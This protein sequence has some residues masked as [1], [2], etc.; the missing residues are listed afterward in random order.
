MHSVLIVFEKPNKT[1]EREKLNN[2][3]PKFYNDLENINKQYEGVE[4]L[5]ENSWMLSLRKSTLSA[6]FFE[7][8]PQWVY[9]S[10]TS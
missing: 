6:L 8:K 7:K 1:K 10:K 9:S 2:S 5:G 4:T 3:W